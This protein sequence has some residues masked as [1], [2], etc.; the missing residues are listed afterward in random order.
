MAKR[1]LSPIILKL[2]HNNTK[3]R[4]ILEYTQKKKLHTGPP[5]KEIRIPVKWGHL[6]AK[7]WGSEHERP[8]LALHG[9]QDN[10]GTWDPYAPMLCDK[11]PILALDF[12]GHG[13]SS[14]IPEGMQYYPWDLPRLILYLKDYFKWDKVSL[15]CHSMGS[16]AGMR[17]AS[18]FPDDIDFY[19]AVDSL[20]YDD[21]DLNQVVAHYSKM[22]RKLQALQ[23][24]KGE[25]PCY[26]MEE[27]IKIWHLGTTKSVAK[28]SVP[29]LLN[30]GAKESSRE[31][32]KYYFSRDPRLKHI[33]F[34]AE[35]KKLVET[36]VKRIKCPTLYFKGIDSPYASDEHSVEM[37][38]TLAQNN[39]DFECHFIPSTHHLHLNNPELIEPIILHFLKKHSFLK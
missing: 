33:L 26:T 32:N 37:R 4:P 17:F 18:V 15:L 25:P 21:Y 35:D 14:W 39:S 11:R 16:I 1:L 27:I 2:N 36:M 20:I 12:P 19:I 30:R 8:I 24:L 29:Y 5:V 34:S 23:D 38:E 31:P 6:A 28:E 9:W 7:L 3:I 22:L 13:F 10:A